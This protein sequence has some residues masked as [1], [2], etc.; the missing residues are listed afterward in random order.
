MTA[1]AALLG[2][3]FGCEV[4]Y[5]QDCVPP[6]PGVS[7]CLD[8]GVADSTAHDDSAQ[9]MTETGTD[10]T[11]W[12]A[13][14]WVA[15]LQHKGLTFDTIQDAIADASDGDTV[16]VSPGTHLELIDFHGKAVH[17]RSTHGPLATVLDGGGTDSVVQI[18]A[19]EPDTAILEGFTIT[20]GK[21]HQGHGGGVFVEN[22]DPVIRHNV[23]VDNVASVGGGVYLRHGYATVTN[24]LFIGNEGGDG[25][26]GIG[27]TNCKGRIAYNTFVDNVG[28]VG[29][30]FEYYY[31]PQADLVGNLIVLP[32][33][34]PYVVR[35]W[36]PLG[37]TFESS[38]NLVW[39]EVPWVAPDAPEWPDGGTLHGPPEFVDQG[40]GDYR[41]AAD[42]PAVDAGPA[43]D[44]DPDGSPADLGAYG[45]ALGDW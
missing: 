10:D 11:G 43:G 28:N 6:P 15:A 34:V 25:G 31:E 5:T 29:T 17:V 13:G 32:D 7:G 9:S 33:D 14:D 30:V 8:T 1:L 18:R 36:E 19:L 41:L 45:G 16:L 12:P 37:Y 21:G 39:P 44:T 20:G 3:L 24:N 4:V 38:H 26:A 22:A 35:Y 23:F 2:V 42:S 40:G 27:C